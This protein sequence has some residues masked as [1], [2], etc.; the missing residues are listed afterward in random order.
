MIKPQITSI[1]FQLTGR[2][3]LR[4]IFCG[5]Q[6]GMFGGCLK[7]RDAEAHRKTHRDTHADRN[8]C[9]GLDVCDHA[10]A[11]RDADGYKRADRNTRA[12]LLTGGAERQRRIQRGRHPACRAR[13]IF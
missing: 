2:C 6:N 3:N 5:Q 9:A 11:D 4:C 8:R 12:D 10:R 13:G 7:D 1:H